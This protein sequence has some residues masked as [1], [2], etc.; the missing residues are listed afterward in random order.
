M[1]ASIYR[2]AVIS[3]QLQNKLRSLCSC[4]SF[5]TRHRLP[6]LLTPGPLAAFLC[7]EF[8]S[9]FGIIFSKGLPFALAYFRSRNSQFCWTSAQDFQIANVGHECNDFGNAAEVFSAPI[10]VDAQD[11][12]VVV[13]KSEL[14]FHPSTRD[15]SKI[16]EMTLLVGQRLFPLANDVGCS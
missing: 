6:G 2:S 13:Q 7:Q 1:Q 4:D 5:T 10:C 3:T 11:A 12:K 8:D 14:P 9:L 15:G 16:V